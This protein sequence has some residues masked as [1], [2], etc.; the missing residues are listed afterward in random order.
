[1]L[2]KCF[3][4]LVGLYLRVREHTFVGLRRGARKGRMS[5]YW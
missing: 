4:K 1:M 5:Q 3:M 2:N